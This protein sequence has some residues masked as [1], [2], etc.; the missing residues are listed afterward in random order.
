MTG[1]ALINLLIQR[2]GSRRDVDIRARCLGELQLA[3]ES[4]C[5]I[6][7]FYPWFLRTTNSSLSTEIDVG[8]VI[9]PSNFAAF[10]PDWGGLFYIDTASTFTQKDVRITRIDDPEYWRYYGQFASGP[11]KR[12]ALG[13]V[14]G[15]VTFRLVPP[16]DALYTLVA[17]YVKK[18]ELLTDSAVETAWTKNAS[19]LL[20]AHAGY[21]LCTKHWR[22]VER[23]AVFEKDI[24]LAKK[25][26]LTVDSARR[27]PDSRNMGEPE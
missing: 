19:D 1:E 6:N 18:D 17:R 11:P 2:L 22:D 5:E 25:R 24:S 7:D 3:Q 15:V 8:D 14:D 20:L 27:E 16:P 4:Q 12:F 21:N 13:D 26:V 23:A 9:A 10:D